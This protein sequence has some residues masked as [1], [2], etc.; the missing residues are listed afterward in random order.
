MGLI[1]FFTRQLDRC[2]APLM[3]LVE[4]FTQLDGDPLDDAC[5]DVIVSDDLEIVGHGFWLK[6]LAIRHWREY[7]QQSSDDTVYRFVKKVFLHSLS[8]MWPWFSKQLIFRGKYP[9]FR[10][11]SYIS[12]SM[13][14]TNKVK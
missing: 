14:R 5:I 1:D 3:S 6:A 10:R 13:S 9:D 11:F 2:R 12:A 4:A 7:L 8:G